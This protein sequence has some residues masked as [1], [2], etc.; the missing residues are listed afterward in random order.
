MKKLFFLLLLSGCVNPG[1]C[2][3]IC[4][5]NGVLYFHGDIC[6]C[7]PAGCGDHKAEESK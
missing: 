2:K 7:Q 6:V 3:S 5:P 4:D 1:E